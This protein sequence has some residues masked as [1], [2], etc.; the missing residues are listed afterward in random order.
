MAPTVV[1]SHIR[2]THHKFRI[3]CRRYVQRTQYS[4]AMLTFFFVLILS[5]SLLVASR[6][7]SG[8]SD[9]PDHTVIFNMDSTDQQT[10]AAIQ[11]FI[12]HNDIQ[13][14]LRQVLT[15]LSPSQTSGMA[16]T[17]MDISSIMSQLRRRVSEK[18]LQ[19]VDNS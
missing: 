7:V 17:A 16:G 5:Q 3:K 1:V 6:P 14:E 13:G 8:P 11:A 12:Q 18:I 15:S 10:A 9:L 4:R 19:I 2:Q